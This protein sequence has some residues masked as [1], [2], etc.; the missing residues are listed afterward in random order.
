ML[1]DEAGADSFGRWMFGAG[2][3]DEY[4]ILRIDVQRYDTLITTHHVHDNSVEILIKVH[5]CHMP[6]RH[7][8]E[9]AALAGEPVVLVNASSRGEP[10][11]KGYVPKGDLHDEPCKEKT[12]RHTTRSSQVI[13]CIVIALEVFS[14]SHSCRMSERLSACS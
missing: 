1:I 4:A 3:M 7:P 13:K 6:E 10:S 8:L 14:R 2:K 11:P 5:D 9:A 12:L